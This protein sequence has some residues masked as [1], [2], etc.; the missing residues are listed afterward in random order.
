M[1][2]QVIESGQTF[3]IIAIGNMY[4]GAKFRT[5]VDDGFHSREMAQEE[6]KRL[7]KRADRKASAK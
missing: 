3:S 1:E 5:I 2:Y 6:C 4:A 7:Q